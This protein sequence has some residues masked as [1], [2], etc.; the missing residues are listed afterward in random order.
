MEAFDQLPETIKSDVLAACAKQCIV[1]RAT[2][3]VLKEE[4][5]QHASLTKVIRPVAGEP[6][7]S[8]G[9]LFDTKEQIGSYFVVEA[10]SME[11]AISVASLHP[12][13]LYGE[14]YGF[15]IEVRPLQ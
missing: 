5:V 11:E 14:E 15:V 13:A 2:G 10:E 9:P 3:K 8:N 6:T 12:A 1:F 4:G 7:V